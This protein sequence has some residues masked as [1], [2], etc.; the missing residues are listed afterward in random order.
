MSRLAADYVAKTWFESENLRHTDKIY[1]IA[2]LHQETSIFTKGDHRRGRKISK[3]RPKS[4]WYGR[5]RILSKL[6]DPRSKTRARAMTS[7]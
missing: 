2:E 3:P 1:S 4:F 5:C 7:S 6:E